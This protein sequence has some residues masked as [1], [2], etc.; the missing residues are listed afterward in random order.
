MCDTFRPLRLTTLARDLDD[1]AYAL[2]WADDTDPG[3][4]RRVARCLRRPSSTRRDDRRGRPVTVH[5]ADDHPGFADPEYRDRRNHIA[6]AR[7]RLGA[8]PADP[9]VDYTEE[10]QE[11]WRT[12]SREL[13]AK[14]ERLAC[15]E[16]REAMAAP[17]TPNRPHPAARRGLGATC[18]R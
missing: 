11:V 10:E 4:G 14:H 15:A 8:G 7:A 9:R 12:V 16:Y 18:S 13:A 17:R 6:V 1:G 2:S 5:L 3:H